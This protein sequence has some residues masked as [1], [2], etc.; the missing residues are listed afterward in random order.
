[1]IDVDVTK[2]PYYKE[3]NG[4][5]YQGCYQYYDMCF[6]M[7]YDNCFNKRICW[8]KVKEF[9]KSLFSKILY[10]RNNGNK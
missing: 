5:E 4:V 2:C 10:R 3:D 7:P 6:K 9:I 8:H 1:M